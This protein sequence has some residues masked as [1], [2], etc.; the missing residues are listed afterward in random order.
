MTLEDFENLGVDLGDTV[1][2]DLPKLGLSE[3]MVIFGIEY[4]PK[5][6]RVR[7]V[8]GGRQQLYEELL[9]EQISGDVAA[10][11]GRTMTLPEQTSTLAYSLDKIARIQADQKHVVYVSK[12][13]L[14][15]YN[16]R[17]VILNPSGEAELVSGAMEGS[18]EVQVLPP[19][20]L[21]VNWV[22]AEWIAEKGERV[23][24]LGVEF[25]QSLDGWQYRKRI[26]IQE[27]AGRDLT[28]YQIKLTIYYGSGTDSGSD[29]YLNEKCRSDFGDIRFADMD[30]N[31]LPYWIEEKADSDYAVFWVK[32]PSIPANGTAD[33]YIYYGNPDAVYDGDP[34]QVFFIYEDMETPPEGMLAGD[35]F[36]DSTNKWI[37]LTRAAGNLKGYLYYDKVPQ[38]GFYAKFRVWAGGGNGADA[39]WLGV[40]DSDY[41]GTTEDIVDGG[42]HFTADEYQDRIAFTKSTSDN[43]A[44]IASASQSGIDDGNWHTYEV[45][46]W[47]SG[48]VAYCKIYWDGVLKVDASDSSPQSNALNKVGK[49]IFGARTGGSYNEH[50]IDDIIIRNYVDPE[51]SISAVGGEEYHLQERRI[52]AG[53]ISASLLNADGEALGQVFDAY[54]T[55]FYR[56]RKWPRG[57]GSLTYKNSSS[58]GANNASASDKREGILHAH[59]LKLT[60]S[61]LG[62]DGEIYYPSSRDLNLDLS[63]AKWLRLYLYA[64]HEDDVTV[65]IRLHQDADN[66]FEGS[67]VVKAK[68]WRKYEIS[69][70]SLSKIGSPSL[71]KINWISIISPYPIL[72]D[73]D[74]VFLPATRELLRVKFTLKRNSPDDPSPKIRLVKIIWREGA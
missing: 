51:P 31:L 59:C 70:D 61:I 52:M 22:K 19:S 62:L 46:F 14:T 41:A 26:T 63:W 40:Y 4:Y 34:K 3:D 48:G 29:I 44:P 71:G 43:G 2:V 20:E 38:Y 33:I 69:M 25:P 60:P 5:A 73:S 68:E 21:F 50:R 53:E 30:G 45:Y 55:Q 28:D 11:F 10:R 15:L 66:Y 7:L 17:N 1:R 65:K 18:F 54:D 74:H 72:I 9:A 24:S 57:Y 8:L 39:I 49:T 56:F 23:E 37:R 35:A 32:V 13:P 58:W 16:A 67:L 64:D 12:P 47:I 6:L 36:Y 27:N 42:Y